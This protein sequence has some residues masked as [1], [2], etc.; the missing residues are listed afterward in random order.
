MN[1]QNPLYGMPP[2]L[3]WTFLICSSLQKT[4]CI[5]TVMRLLIYNVSGILKEFIAMRLQLPRGPSTLSGLLRTGLSA[6]STHSWGSLQHSL[7][8]VWNTRHHLSQ[9]EWVRGK[10]NSAWQF[11][12]WAGVPGLACSSCGGRGKTL[13]SVLIPAG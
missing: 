4:S 2:T 8:A 9:A 6:Q 11:E 3:P 10:R 7:P 12:P 1:R 5:V 13:P